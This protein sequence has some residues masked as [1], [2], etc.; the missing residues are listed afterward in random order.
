MTV[1]R[2]RS[3]PASASSSGGTCG[4]PYGGSTMTPSGTA[5]ASDS[6]SR[7]HPLPDL[8]VDQLEVYVGDPFRER[9]R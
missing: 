4:S 5:S 9:A 3:N 8:R 7:A 6:F 1:K 2:S